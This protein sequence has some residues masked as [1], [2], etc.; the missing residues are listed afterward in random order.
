MVVYHG[1]PHSYGKNLQGDIVAILDSNKNVVV[2]YVYDAWGR[3]ISKT[4]TLASTLGTVQPFRYRSYVY[5]EET[6]LYY[7]RSR[8]YSVAMHR[9]IIVDSRICHMTGNVEFA[10]FAY[11]KNNPVSYADPNGTTESPAF[12]NNFYNGNNNWS[13]YDNRRR[14]PDNPFHEQMF[15]VTLSGLGGGYGINQDGEREEKIIPL[16]ISADLATAGWEFEVVDNVE[17]DLSLFDFCHAELGIEVSSEGVGISAFASMYS[18]S[19]SVSVGNVK[20]EASAEIGSTGFAV[21]ISK[22]G[23]KFSIGGAFGFSFGISW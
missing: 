23:F 3:P 18:P 1:V 22:N 12:I 15:S 11:C 8:Y 17:V 5:D 13:L 20:I 21:H 2:S 14:Q 7:L 16:H 9:F 10:P 4:G 6:G 19:A